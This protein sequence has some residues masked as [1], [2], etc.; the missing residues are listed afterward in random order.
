VSIFFK[1]VQ[2]EQLPDWPGAVFD[3]NA[4][5]DNAH[6]LL[7]FLHAHCTRPGGSY[8]VLKEPGA[9]FLRVFDLR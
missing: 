2:T 7:S 5:L 3:A 9:D 6:A 1:V 4:V 8:W